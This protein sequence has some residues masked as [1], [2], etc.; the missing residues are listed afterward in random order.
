MCHSALF[1]CYKASRNRNETVK[2]LS[3]DLVLMNF[4]ISSIVTS[5]LA[6]V[7]HR[8][9]EI[10]KKDWLQHKSQIEAK[11]YHKLGNFLLPIGAIVITKLGQLCFIIN[12]A[13]RYYKFGQ[14]HFIIN[15]GKCYYKFGLFTN[16]KR[17][18]YRTF[19]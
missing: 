19:N 6:V 2:I 5:R 14:L 7:V 4:I 8:T 13:K 3:H 10:A 17:P 9:L 15:W 11:L 12:W 18:I 16:F 1:A